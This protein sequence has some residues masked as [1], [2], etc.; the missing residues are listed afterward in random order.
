[1]IS[2]LENNSPATA[3]H[4]T[5]AVGRSSP[6]ST[7]SWIFSYIIVDRTH[8]VCGSVMEAVSVAISHLGFMLDLIL[9][10]VLTRLR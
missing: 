10:R 3:F 6:R 7:K 5:S 9:Q 1:L 8:A 4:S 2:S